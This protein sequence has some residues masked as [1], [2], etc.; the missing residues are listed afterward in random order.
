MTWLPLGVMKVPWG[1]GA[2]GQSGVVLVGCVLD[3][4]TV[5][6][7]DYSVCWFL[8]Y[9]RFLSA[10]SCGLNWR[11]DMGSPKKIRKHRYFYQ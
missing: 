8:V 11:G 4:M 2:D 6:V 3:D 7:S 5:I 1:L 9:F 10:I